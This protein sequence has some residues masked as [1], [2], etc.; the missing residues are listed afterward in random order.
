MKYVQFS[1]KFVFLLMLVVLLSSFKCG[2]KVTTVTLAPPP[3]GFNLITEKQ[4]NDLFPERNKFYTYAAFMQAVNELGAIKVN[5]TRRSTYIYQFMR[6]DKRT[7]KTTMVRQDPDWNEQWAT[8]KPDTTYTIDYGAFCTEADAQTNKRELAAF[9]A[10]IAHET[11]HGRNGTYTDGLMLTREGDTTQNYFNGSDE[12][13]PVK[14]KK[15]YG[16]G[17]M[18]LSY[19]GNYGYA[20]DLIFGDYKVLLNDPDLVERDPVVAFK[21]A[22]YFW[23]TPQKPKPSAHD[24]MIGKWKPHAADIAGKRSAG[25][26]MTINIINGALECGKGE[27]LPNMQSRINFY[28]HFLKQLGI[29]DANCVCSCGG[30]QA[31]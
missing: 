13:P 31:Y 2:S 10:N 14:G 20:S 11:R 30:M 16:R 18:Q 3:A 12:Y 21:A 28:Q 24:V 22:I 29:T 19:N 9:F 25:F 15:Y 27:D 6:T 1:S 26:G 23:M 4:F 5:I 8:E 17:P 7:N